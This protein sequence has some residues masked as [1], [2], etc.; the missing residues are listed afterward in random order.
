VKI[1]PVE[2]DRLLLDPFR[3]KY[4]TEEYVSWLNDP[5]TVRYSEQRH[6]KHTLGSCREYIS[7]LTESG[8][9]AMWAVVLKDAGQH[10]GNINVYIDEPN[11]VADIG[12]LIRKSSWGK[13]YGT[14]AFKALTCW[15]F[16]DLKIRKV[17]AGCVAANTGMIK[18]AV[19]AGMTEDGR[20]KKQFIIGGKETDA[21]YMARFLNDRERKK[22]GVRNEIQ[23]SA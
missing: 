3:E 5:E 22:N 20:R 17:T 21:I 12:L 23:N 15:L 10:I 19:K 11:S 2:T 9:A 14:E 6:K 4:L 7:C 13:G 8:T 18:T 16:D 1:S